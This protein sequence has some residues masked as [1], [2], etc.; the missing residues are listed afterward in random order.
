MTCRE[1]AQDELNI[2][3]Q[4]RKSNGIGSKTLRVIWD[5]DD[6]TVEERKFVHKLDCVLMTIVSQFRSSS[7]VNAKP[8]A[9]LGYF[10]KYLSQANIS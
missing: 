1:P 9:I 2:L 8:Q 10:V 6:K 4:G 3:E 7:V 5:N